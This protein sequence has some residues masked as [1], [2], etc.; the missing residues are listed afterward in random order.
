MHK[1]DVDYL[2][3]SLAASEGEVARIVNMGLDSHMLGVSLC[4]LASVSIVK[5]PIEGT[6]LSHISNY[7]MLQEDN[8]FGLVKFLIKGCPYIS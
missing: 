7:Y 3:W 4:H 6:V 2:I 5:F 8:L 1:G